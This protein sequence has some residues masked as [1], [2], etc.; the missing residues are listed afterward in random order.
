MVL[1]DEQYLRTPF[2]GV[3]K[4]TEWLRRKSHNVN[5]RRIHRLMRQMGLEAIYPRR[6]RGLSIADKDIS[7]LAQECYCYA[8]GSGM[9]Y[10][11]HVCSDV[12]WLVVFDGDNGL[13]QPLCN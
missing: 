8:F 10:G 9:G 6:K 2:Y 4:M 11:H 12:S 7:V 1:I 13:V 5:P 3:D